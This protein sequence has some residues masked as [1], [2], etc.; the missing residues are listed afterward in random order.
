MHPIH[1]VIVAPNVRLMYR[2]VFI[3]WYWL[4]EVFRNLH[5]SVVLALTTLSLFKRFGTEELVLLQK[6]KR[7]NPKQLFK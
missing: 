6:Q 4:G 3:E 7:K 5:R 2:K 1:S